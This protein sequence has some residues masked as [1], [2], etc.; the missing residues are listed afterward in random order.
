MKLNQRENQG[1]AA[2]L[3]LAGAV[4]LAGGCG[5]E[6]GKPATTKPGMQRSA[7]MLKEELK[8]IEEE[9]KRDRERT[10]EDWAQLITETEELQRKTVEAWGQHAAM[11]DAPGARAAAYN[12]K[13]GGYGSGAREM[14]LASF[15]RKLK[16]FTDDQ[17]VRLGQH[18][19]AEHR[20][21]KY[22]YERAV[23]KLEAARKHQQ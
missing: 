9:A 19:K 3:V 1:P 14:R 16:E 7:D 15:R 2:A 10:R 4:L 6:S 21:A 23:E 17:V 8:R 11:K 13:T 22:R 18:I 5:G 20:S 12:H